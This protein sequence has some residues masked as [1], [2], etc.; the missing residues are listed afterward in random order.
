MINC[1]L[2]QTIDLIF[3]YQ[4]D[5]YYNEDTHRST[6]ATDYYPYFGQPSM[7]SGQINTFT[8]YLKCQ[9]V[10]LECGIA[11][12]RERERLKQMLLSGIYI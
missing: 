4:E 1:Y 12:E 8:G 5:I 6:I 9:S 10:K 7:R 2:P 3:E 11:T